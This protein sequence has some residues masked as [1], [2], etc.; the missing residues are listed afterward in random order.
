MTKSVVAISRCLQT[1]LFL[2]LCAPGT[3]WA[4]QD[5]ATVLGTVLDSSQAVVAGAE[6]VVQNQE[7]GREY[8]LT[9][10]SS[11]LF[12][13]PEIPVGTYRVTASLQ[14]FK[15]RV[16]EGIVLRVSDRTR[17]VLTLEPGELKEIVTVTGE[18]SLIESASNTLGG[19]IDRAQVQNLPLNGR[20]PN[21]L[22]AQVP[23]VNLRGN[24]FQQSMNGLNTGGQSVS[25]VTF[26]MD[27]VDASRVDAQTITITYGR[28]QNR[29]ARVNT[30]GIQEFRIYQNSFSAE[31]GSSTGAAVNIITRSGANAFHGSAFEF[32]RNEKLD[33]RNYF[34]RC[35]TPGCTQPAKPAFRLNQFGGSFGGPIVKDKAFFFGSYEGIR[36]R[37]GTTL[38]AL[39]PTQAFRDTLPAVLQPV[40]GMLPLPNAGASADPRVGFR[41]EGRSGF[42]DEDSVFVRVDFN[43]TAKDRLSTRYNANSSLTKTH[44]GVG[45]GQIAPSAG[46]LQSAKITYTRTFS[47]TLVNEASFAFNRMHID[48]KGSIDPTIAAFPVTTTGGMASIGPA[49]FDLSMVGNSFTSL[50]TLSWVNGRNQF[51]FGTQI[52]RNQHNKALFNQKTVSYANLSDFALNSPTAD[53][54]LGYDRTGLR[55]TYYNFFV[56][57]NIQ[58]TRKLSVM[59]GL[60]YQFESSPSDAN[61]RQANFD[62]STGLD[63]PGAQLM[64]MPK[65]NF[66]P[67]LSFAYSPFDSGKTVIRGAYGIYHVNFNATLV[68]NTPINT[69]RPTTVSLTRVQQPDLVGF[70]FP[71]VSSFSGVRTLSAVQRDWD[72][73]YVQN[74]NLNIQQELANNLRLQVGYVA[75]KGSH[76]ITPAMDLNRFLPGTAVRP[77]PGYGSITYLQANGVSSY[78]SMQVV[79]TKRLARGLQFDVNYTW[80]HALDDSPPIFS[81][82]SDDHNIHLDYGTTESDVKHLL[83]FDYVYQVPAARVLPRWLGEGWQLNGITEMRSGLPINVACGCDPLRVSQFTSRADILPGASPLPS[84]IVIPSKQLN[85]AAFAAPPTGRIGNVARGAFRGPAVYNFDFSLFK[86]FSIERHEF[87]FRAEFFNI[88][89]TPQFNLPGSSIVSPGNFG[90][91]TSTLT[92]VSN[93]GTQRQIQF[94][95][96]YN[97]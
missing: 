86:R 72:T 68:Q 33:A 3:S 54:L 8:R 93:F 76:I 50:D 24:M 67:R 51:K 47:P 87:Q 79:L 95:L 2:L 65:T 48:P 80:G 26:L 22:L 97:F 71:D 40:A 59:A 45:T 94:G 52:I 44:F 53:G 11:G 9:T 82:S 73:P 7:T 69:G 62:P 61:D 55:N 70:P 77:Y 13:A 41:N 21:V 39:V 14:G 64:N 15:T 66:G 63:S 28:S 78:N 88:F 96:R 30:E 23:G 27:G 43:L 42:L 74:W 85:I 89:N 4:Q 29:I 91:S 1:S 57:D 46:L 83:S 35:T 19:T 36:Q 60:R 34:N 84:P 32:L 56:E 58:A 31:F 6:V 10:D 92:T 12:V 16:Q 90:V 81:A 38:V 18:T 17:L 5:R 20:D 49:L 37:T 25:L 75:N